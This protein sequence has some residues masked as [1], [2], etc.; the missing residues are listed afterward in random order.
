V[1]TLDSLDA[2]QADA[3]FAITVDGERQR[4]F[5]GQK[6]CVY[7]E[8]SY[9][10]PGP[11]GAWAVSFRGYQSEAEVKVK[12][13]R[14]E[15]SLRPGDLRV[16]VPPSTERSYDAAKKGDIVPEVIRGAFDE[17]PKLEAKEFCLEP[18]KTYQAVVT[19]EHF[20]LPPKPGKGPTTRTHLVLTVSDVPFVDGKSPTPLTPAYRGRTY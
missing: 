16:H 10:E 11:D 8:W 2:L 7:F 13:P 1:P 9:G 18:G 15:L 3:P 17:H 12:T 4:S 5:L 14:G 19:A 6:A 20:K